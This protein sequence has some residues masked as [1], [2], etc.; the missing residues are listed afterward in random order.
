MCEPNRFWYIQTRLRLR[1]WFNLKNFCYYIYVETKN[2]KEMLFEDAMPLILLLVQWLCTLHWIIHVLNSK[3]AYVDEH[4]DCYGQTNSNLVSRV[5]W[6]VIDIF[7][8]FTKLICWNRASVVEKRWTQV[9][10]TVIKS[11][12]LCTWSCYELLKK[13]TIHWERGNVGSTWD[14]C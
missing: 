1:T 8:A 2:A 12:H 14:V 3:W 4:F 5:W 6:L 10:V 13:I 7:C 9:C 11:G